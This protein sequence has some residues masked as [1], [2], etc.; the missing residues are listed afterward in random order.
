[1]ETCDDGPYRQLVQLPGLVRTPPE[2]PFQLAPARLLQLSVP[3]PPSS[4]ITPDYFAF[5]VIGVSH[6]SRIEDQGKLGS[7]RGITTIPVSVTK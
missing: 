2:T 7:S 3:L 4:V 6:W 1:M 5:S